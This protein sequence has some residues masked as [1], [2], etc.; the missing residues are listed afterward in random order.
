[1]LS[2]DPLTHLNSSSSRTMWPDAVM[3]HHNISEASVAETTDLEI[4][5]CLNN[6]AVSFLALHMEDLASDLLRFALKF[7]AG[8][9]GLV[10]ATQVY[11]QAISWYQQDINGR[12]HEGICA[13][14]GN[15]AT[16][17]S[18]SLTSLPF[19]YT[20]GIPLIPSS[21]AFSTSVLRSTTVTSSIL[22]FNMGVAYHVHA[23][24]GGSIDLGRLARARFLYLKSLFL[25]RDSKFFTDM[26]TG[27]V[28]PVLD[29]LIMALCNNLGQTSYEAGAYAEARVYFSRMVHYA[30]TVDNSAE[31]TN[32]SL[33][34]VTVHYHK[35]SLLLNAMIL[36]T[37]TAAPAA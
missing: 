25:L 32:D 18:P 10:E 24:R 36:R 11:Q 30:M 29:L 35:T 8:R 2:T 19:V 14:P 12:N 16:Q 1:M 9:I 28:H 6:A 26:S 37:P 27:G 4:V 13:G 34:L 33:A 23:L 17:D 3:E 15:I 31:Y 5:A 20:E 7:A 21:T 22:I